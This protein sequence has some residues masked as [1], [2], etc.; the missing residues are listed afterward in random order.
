MYSTWV[1][2]APFSTLSLPVRD[3]E[4]VGVPEPVKSSGGQVS[5]DPP[6]QASFVGA[7][8]VKWFLCCGWTKGIHA[9]FL[10]DSKAQGCFYGRV[11]QTAV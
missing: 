1:P 4:P 11:Q 8:G 10:G 3:V 6:E 7:S 9:S 2:L 5:A